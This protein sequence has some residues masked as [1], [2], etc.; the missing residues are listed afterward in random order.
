MN[1]LQFHGECVDGKGDPSDKILRSYFSDYDYKGTIV[2][3][4]GYDPVVLS[5]S[6]HFEKNGW[7]AYC[8]E[9]NHL[10]FDK[11]KDR[12]NAL[13]F[14]CSDFDGD[15]VPFNVVTSSGWTAGF[16]SLTINHKAIDRFGGPKV[17]ENIENIKVKVRKLDTLLEKEM[18]DVKKIDILTVD[19]EGGEMNVLKGFDIKKWMPTVVFIEDIFYNDGTS[20]LS[21]YMRSV[22]YK[23]D[24]RDDYNCYY[25]QE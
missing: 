25:V 8:L 7:L 15:D 20:D 12:K 6:Y 19:V 17:I 16:S 22:G 3:V 11:F 18:S 2:E 21:N 9:A 24:R 13:N 14:A 5:T 10:D 1:Y 4:G 23:I